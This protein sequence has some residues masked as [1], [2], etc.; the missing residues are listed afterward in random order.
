MLVAATRIPL[1]R[2]EKR[3]KV[4]WELQGYLRTRGNGHQFAARQKGSQKKPHKF[5]RFFKEIKRFFA[6]NM[7]CVIS[8]I[9]LKLFFVKEVHHSTVMQHET[10]SLK[11][12][13]K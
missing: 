5:Y 1:I 3:E 6:E 13:R 2:G 7:F 9:D 4:T 12:H 11:V 8:F 10:S